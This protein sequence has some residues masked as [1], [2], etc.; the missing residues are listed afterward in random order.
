MFKK[1][2][3]WILSASLLLVILGCNKLTTENYDLL[4]VG[5]S[6]EQVEKILGE[7]DE[8]NGAIGIKNCTWGHEEKYIKVS[9]AGDRVAVFSGHGLPRG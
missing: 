1:S 7:V 6:M 9:F 3:F 8:C 2:M 4:E 5:M